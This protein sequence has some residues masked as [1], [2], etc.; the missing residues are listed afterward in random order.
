MSHDDFAFEPIRGLPAVL[1]KGET[2]LWQGSPDWKA[3]AVGAY[4]VRKVAVYFLIL[5]AWRVFNGVNAGHTAAAI[6]TGCLWLLGLGCI[7]LALLSL[8]AYW[9][10]RVTVY[11]I[12][13]RRVLLRHGIAVQMTMNVPFDLLDSAGVIPRAL[14]T[15][16]LAMGVKKEHRVGYVVTWPHVRP[17]YFARPQPSFRALA[18]APQ[19]GAVLQA[20]LLAQAAPGTIRMSS[21]AAAPEP[22][23]TV[24]AGR[25]TVATA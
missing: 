16:D 24:G 13:N 17:G 19:A 11:S 18:D 4:H 3:L 10:A 5:L 20:A 8:L 14:G 23:A 2:L 25:R 21:G 12:T 22:G 1:P 15:G 7:A 9:S 6:A